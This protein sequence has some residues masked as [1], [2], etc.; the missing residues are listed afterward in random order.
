M[1]SGYGRGHEQNGK[2][3]EK[4]DNQRVAEQENFLTLVATEK[5]HQVR[6]YGLNTFL[7]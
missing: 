7:H 1:I 5:C 2:M 6:G 4:E 3:S